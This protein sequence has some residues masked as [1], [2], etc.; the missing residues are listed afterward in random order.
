VSESSEA[1]NE[2][3]EIVEIEKNRIQKI[4]NELRESKEES[5]STTIKSVRN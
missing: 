1:E 3:R 4:V 5:F 2:K